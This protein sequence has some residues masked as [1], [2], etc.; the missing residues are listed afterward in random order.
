[1]A[2]VVHGNAELI[3][4]N[5]ALLAA[6]TRPRLV[7]L[8]VHAGPMQV[9][10]IQQL[11]GAL[12]R[13]LPELDTLVVRGD[14]VF[15][16]FAHP[17]LRRLRVGGFAAFASLAGTG[18]AMP[19]LEELDFSVHRN[20]ASGL[21]PLPTVAQLGRMLR[22]VPALRRLDLSRNEPVPAYGYGAP[23]VFEATEFLR[24][25]AIKRQLTHLR[26][27]ALLEHRHVAQLQASLD[28]MPAL[29]ELEVVRV[30]LGGPQLDGEPPLRHPSARIVVPGPSEW[31]PRTHQRG[32]DAICVEV[33]GHPYGIVVELAAG[34]RLMEE[35][36]QQMPAPARAAW[37][38]LW[39]FLDTVPLG[40]GAIARAAFP[41]TT[42]AEALALP[43]LDDAAFVE[44][45]APGLAA[46]R[47]L[48][49]VLAVRGRFAVPAM[50]RRH[51][52]W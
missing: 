10:P 31:G 44:R 24:E 38:R 33:R 29:A 4:T 25:L 23:P 18:A 2:L 19:A 3:G 22:G 28:R 50:I 37:E 35:R 27:P 16:A 9:S 15:P 47:T 21:Y 52:G 30:A 36:F 43:E 17:R 5:L 26:M 39:H 20:L 1:R 48:R 12:R 6:E 51:Y 49:D 13:A 32:R 40:E 46:W 14:R 34:V 11:A 8:A 7:R 41:A 42:L 45:V